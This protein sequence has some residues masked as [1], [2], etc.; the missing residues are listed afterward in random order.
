MRFSV[1]SRPVAWLAVALITV[2]LAASLPVATADPARVLSRL[3]GQ[4]LV[5]LA[6]EGHGGT[7]RVH[8]SLR[9][10]SGVVPMHV[11]P[12][13]QATV[14]AHGTLRLRGLPDVALTGGVN[15]YLVMNHF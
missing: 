13:E 6:R 9:T 4:L 12:S 11:A 2:A 8:V 7:T 10:G 14:R 3:D 5:A 1:R 15:Y